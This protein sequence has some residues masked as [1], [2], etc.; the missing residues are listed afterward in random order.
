MSEML[1]YG[2]GFILAA[3]ALVT[4]IAMGRIDE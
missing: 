3:L 1:V 2:F 4:V